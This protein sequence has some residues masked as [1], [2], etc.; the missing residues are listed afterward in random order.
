MVFTLTINKFAE[1]V[2]LMLCC[3]I[4]TSRLHFWGLCIVSYP[5]MCK[6]TTKGKPFAWIMHQKLWMN[7]DNDTS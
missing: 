7:Q 3:C 1:Y 5:R 2:K 4:T 6:H